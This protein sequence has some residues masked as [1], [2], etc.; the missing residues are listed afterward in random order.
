MRE[1]WDAAAGCRNNMMP[2]LTMLATTDLMRQR[3]FIAVQHHFECIL[4]FLCTPRFLSYEYAGSV[5]R[6][7]V[8]E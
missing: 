8:T 4:L 3:C 6:T 2:P 7:V 1:Q 5:V